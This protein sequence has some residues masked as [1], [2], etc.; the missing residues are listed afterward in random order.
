MWSLLGGASANSSLGTDRQGKECGPCIGR[1]Q[2]E[3]IIVTNRI[4]SAESIGKGQHELGTVRSD[5]V[6]VQ[7]FK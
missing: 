6:G 2:C 4:R 3:L 1:G 5:L 7:G